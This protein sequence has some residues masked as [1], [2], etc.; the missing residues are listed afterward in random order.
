MY[1]SILY[2]IRKVCAV[3]T[4]ANLGGLLLVGHE[5][6]G[7]ED[8]HGDGC[9][10]RRHVGTDASGHERP[11]IFLDQLFR[12][13]GK[14]QVGLEHSVAATK[15]EEEEKKSDTLAP[16]PNELTSSVSLTRYE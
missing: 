11:T 6:V 8:G 14:R 12:G 13:G 15:E 3:R 7:D 5:D 4:I 9:S 16:C 10:D 2:Y 1:K